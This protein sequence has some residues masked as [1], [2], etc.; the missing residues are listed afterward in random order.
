MKKFCKNILQ[1]LNLIEKNDLVVFLKCSIII[2]LQ[3]LSF[4][5]KPFVFVELVYISVFLIF[6]K[7]QNKILYLLFL[8]PFYNVFRYG[9]DNTQYNQILNNFINVYFSVWILLLFLVLF[10]FRYIKDLKNKKKSLKTNTIICFAIL[11]FMLFIPQFNIIKSLSTFLVITALFAT[12]YLVFEYKS[13]LNLKKMANVWFWGVIYS[14]LIYIF[15]DYLPYLSDYGITIFT[16]RFN[17]LLRDPNY[18]SFEILTLLLVYTVL[19]FNKHIKIL[20]PFV[21]VILSVS[22]VLSQSKAFL[23]AFIVYLVILLTMLIIKGYKYYSSKKNLNQFYYVL[24]LSV[25][26]ILVIGCV[27]FVA[28]KDI[29]IGYINRFFAFIIFDGDLQ[30]KLNQLTTG[31]YSIWLK[32][33]TSIIY[34]PLV[35]LWGRG[36]CNGYEFEPIHNTYLQIFY[37]GG[38]LFC[39]GFV[40]WQI[41]SIIKH[42]KTRKFINYLP[43]LIL[44]IM[45]CSIDLLFSYRFFIILIFIGLTMDCKNNDTCTKEKIKVSNP[46]ISVIVPVYKVETYLDACIES[47]LNQPYKN[48]ELILV[49]DKSPDNCGKMCD[50]W[51]KKDPRIKVIHQK[52][53]SGVSMARNSGLALATGHYVTFVDSDDYITNDF[54]RCIEKLND[55]DIMCVPYFEKIKSDIKVKIPLYD[56]QDTMIE[57]INE[58]NISSGLYNSLCFKIF[59]RDFIKKNNL[60]LDKNLRIAEDLK[61]S[62]ESFKYAKSIQFCGIPYYVYNRNDK[63][64]M[65][66]V[67]YEKIVNTLD[68]CEYGKGLIEG[69]QDENLKVFMKKLISENLLSVLNRVGDYTDEQNATLLDR[70][71]KL[72][73]SFVYGTTIIKK[74]LVVIVRIFGIKNASKILNLRGKK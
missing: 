1:E 17:G 53:N 19:F 72:K 54:S 38:L 65:S 40:I 16:N 42:K 60:L 52:V 69:I 30:Q 55:V 24:F 64:A 23:I 57:D 37:F 5:F 68:V 3:I 43:L 22:G 12:L 29:L 48:L 4:F 71:I 63:S 39:I 66:N 70:L 51:K 21:F 11:Y 62:L 56:W 47:I 6:E 9:N 67:S 13:E 59:K 8:L 18:W 20:F 49:D 41:K 7:N 73:K 2:L 32:Y 74:I 15:K 27:I 25:S 36:V 44:G 61:F 26:I 34:T 35:L 58:G 31:R 50:A 33:L 46:K 28:F 14:I 45:A 10:V